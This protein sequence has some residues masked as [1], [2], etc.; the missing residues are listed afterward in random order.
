M[1]FVKKRPPIRLLPAW[2]MSNAVATLV[3]QNLGAG[4][5]ERAERSVWLTSYYNMAFLGA[6]GIIFILFAP[7]LVA[8]FTA[9]PAVIAPGVSCLRIVS[10]GYL[11]Y[12]FGMVV[13]QA[14]NGAGDTATPM[15]INLFCFWL[16]QIPLAYGL[17]HPAGLG[18][19][20]VFI[21]IPVAESVMAVVS[22]LVFRRG[23]LEGESTVMLR[24][25]LR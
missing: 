25:S 11:F 20:G 7:A 15:V 10:Y 6:V 19:N 17:A 2:G 16:L 22:G 12:A 13:V 4:R 23:N 24:Q 9:D 1:G 3:G 8:L 21:A 14:F 5:P 18:P